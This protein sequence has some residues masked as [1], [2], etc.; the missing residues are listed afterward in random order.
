MNRS[1]PKRYVR[2]RA[3]LQNVFGGKQFVSELFSYLEEASIN[4]RKEGKLYVIPDSVDIID[5]LF[6]KE[7][8]LAFKLNKQKPELRISP[9]DLLVHDAEEPATA[10]YYLTPGTTITGE[11]ILFFTFT[12]AESLEQNLGKF[13]RFINQSYTP[14]EAIREVNRKYWDKLSSVRNRGEWTPDTLGEENLQEIWQRARYYTHR[15]YGWIGE[16]PRGALDLDEIIEH[17]MV[18]VIR[19]VKRPLPGLAAFICRKI[20]IQLMGPEK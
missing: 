3:A 12:S 14:P 7:V 4:H 5:T 15:N 13:Q 10:E 16:E 17:V 19:R 9:K 2:A 11:Q 18:E 6:H 1:R 8:R 20:Q